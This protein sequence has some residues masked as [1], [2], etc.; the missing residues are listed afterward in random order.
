MTEDVRGKMTRGAAWMVLFKFIDRGIGLVS[1]LI[2]ARLLSPDNFGVIAMAMSFIALLELIGAFGFDAAIIQRPNA[3][4]AH[5]NTAWTFNVIL[6]ATIAVLMIV[7]SGPVSVYYKEPALAWVIRALALGSLLQGFSNIG[8]VAFRKELNFQKEFVFLLSKRLITFP[9]TIGLAFALRNYWALVIGVVSGR[10]LE[11]FI[12]YRIHP[13]RPRLALSAAG[14]LLQFSKWLLL[15]NILGFIKERAHDFIVGR[16]IG[17]RGLGLFNVTYELASLPGTEL[18]A[19][20]NRAVFPAYAKIAADQDALRREY[21]SVMALIL[22]LAV[23]AVA[24]TAAIAKLAV[25]LLLGDQWLDA[26]PLLQ[27]LAFFGITQVMQSNAYALCLASGRGKVFTWIHAGYVAVLIPLLIVCIRWRGL[28]GAAIGYLVTA[29]VMLP[30]TFTIVMR[31]LRIRIGLFL[32][33]VWR[34]LVSAACMFAVVVTAI[35][36]VPSTAPIATILPALVGAVALGAAT[37]VGT[38]ALLW[39]LARS[40]EGA[41]A[42]VW[43]KVRGVV[44]K[45]RK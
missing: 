14:D 24:G 34:P 35:R 20:I 9:V 37:Y 13:Y 32:A 2:L 36:N 39:R 23:P 30:I 31:I 28:E 10:A 27:L 19:P 16:M 33:N 12:S 42:A 29:L 3:T 44:A 21:L 40:P 18:V 43:G 22:L 7:F 26:V 38:V 5:Y 11:L 4:D 25:P 17:A 41:E 45:R 8:T 15:L 1:T 6:G